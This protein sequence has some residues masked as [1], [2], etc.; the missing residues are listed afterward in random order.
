MCRLT[1]INDIESVDMETGEFM[2]N[3]TEKRKHTGASNPDNEVN[4]I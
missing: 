2:E 4:N 1:H 3:D